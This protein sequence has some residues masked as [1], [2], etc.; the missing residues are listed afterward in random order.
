MFKIKYSDSNEELVNKTQMK[1]WLDAYVKTVSPRE[2]SRNPHVKR[3]IDALIFYRKGA[4]VIGYDR[5]E[6]AKEV[7]SEF[8]KDI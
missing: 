7:L 3:L 1:L 8:D 6:K 4:P 2:L 5:G